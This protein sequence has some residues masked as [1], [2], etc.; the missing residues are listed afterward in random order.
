MERDDRLSE[1]NFGSRWNYSIDKT[2]M[3]KRLIYDSSMIIEEKSVYIVTD[4]S[5]Y[6]DRQ[7]ANVS[8]ILLELVGVN[9]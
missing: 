7:L 1:F 6:Y 8:S 5:T 4:L 3:E 2:L 9:R